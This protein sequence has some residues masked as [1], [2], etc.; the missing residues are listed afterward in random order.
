MKRDYRIVNVRNTPMLIFDEGEMISDDIVK[1]NDF[2]EYWVFIP[3]IKY[4]PT[5]GLLLDIGANIGNHA[6]QFKYYLPNLEIWCFEPFYENFKVL[7]QNT[8]QFKDVVPINIGVGSNT[9][10]VTF[11][12]DDSGNSGISKIVPDGKHKNMVLSIDSINFNDRN[13]TM[14]K[15]DV[16]GHEYSVIEGAINTILQH[17]P[18]IWIED[19]NGRSVNLL[20]SIGYVIIEEQRES[21]FL[22]KYGE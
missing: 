8:K 21:N 6:L 14:I 3:W 22:M 12:D 2:Y 10:I 9:S 16:E 20:K 1:Y 17:K 15:L 4:F 7:K 13:I 11:S 19:F 18:I 5:N